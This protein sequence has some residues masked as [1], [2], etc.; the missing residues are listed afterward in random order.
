MCGLPMPSLFS[1]STL[2]QVKSL[3]ENIS[4]GVKL[5]SLASNVCLSLRDIFEM[6]VPTKPVP[7][8]THAPNNPL[9]SYLWILESKANAHTRS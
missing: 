4:E 2:I 9:N 7:M 1:P 6:A 5:V 8:C 3:T